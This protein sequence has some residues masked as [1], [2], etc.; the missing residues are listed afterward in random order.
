MRVFASVAEEG[1]FAAASRKLDISPAAVTRA[2]VA[3]E[4]QLGARLL[5]RTTRHVRFTDAGR[6]YYEN[7]RAI[8]VSITEANEAVAE[9]NATPRGTL[10]ITAPVMFGRMF[11]MPCLIDYMQRYP[12]VKMVANLVDRVTNLVDE[13][14]DV[15]IRI[16]HLPDS[17][18]RAIKVGEVRRILCASP[19]YLEKSGTPRQ[20]AD[21][22]K[23]SIISS[24][25]VSP[26]TEWHFK[27]NHEPLQVRMD[28]RLTVTSNDAALAAAIGDLGIARLLSYQV[29][30]EV[31][32]DAL[33]MILEGYEE[34]P[35][36]VHVVH[37]EDKLGSSKVRSFIDYVVEY[38]RANPKL[39]P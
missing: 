22:S 8:L 27:T 35:W 34:E 26:H 24:S 20:P 32:T 39:N 5:Q 31:E 13:G 16:G 10:S 12:Q 19:A 11:V 15:A 25:A 9:S 2:V 33:R 18:L 38:L 36:P 3:L 17:G 37:R 29:W 7:V 30:N 23:H 1:G 28:P 14:M 4:E 6:Q 21:L